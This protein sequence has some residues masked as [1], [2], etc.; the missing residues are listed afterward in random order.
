MFL[1]VFKVYLAFFLLANRKDRQ[2]PKFLLKHL[3]MCLQL[4]YALQNQFSFSYV[5]EERNLKYFVSFAS[6]S[7]SFNV[8]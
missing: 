7:S 2:S 5:D 6:P 8:C 4:F 3:T 1:L